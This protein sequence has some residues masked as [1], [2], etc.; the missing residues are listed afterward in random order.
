M[1]ELDQLHARLARFK[2]L[3]RGHAARPIRWAP[4]DISTAPKNGSDGSTQKEGGLGALAP[5]RVAG[6]TPMTTSTI[7]ARPPPKT[8]RRP[9]ETAFCIFVGT[10]AD[11]RKAGLAPNLPCLTLPS[12]KPQAR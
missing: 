3:R 10:G 5:E 9:D 8:K 7:I 12:E 1:L 4:R 11:T 6:H 2:M